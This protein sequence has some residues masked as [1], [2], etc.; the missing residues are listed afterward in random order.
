MNQKP[1]NII[2]KSKQ[3]WAF[4]LFI[5]VVL[6]LV[7]WSGCVTEADD[8]IIILETQTGFNTL[9]EAIKEAKINQT[10]QLKPGV[11]YETIT[12]DKPLK[13]S[14]T[15]RNS[16]IIDGDGNGD[17]IFIL[18]DWVE[19]HNLTIRNSGNQT[20][21]DEDAGV[22][23][24]SEYNTFENLNIS[25]NNNYGLFLYL[26]H[27]NTVKNCVFYQNEEGGA[28]S[29]QCRGNRFENCSFTS[30]DRGIYIHRDNNGTFANNIVSH[31]DIKGIYFYGSR[32]F[33][34]QGNLFSGNDIGMH[35]KGSKFSTFRNN[36]YMGNR[37]GIDFCCGGSDNTVYQNAFMNS[38]EM[39]VTG[40]PINQFDNGSI[41]NFWDDYEGVDENGDGIG[42]T[43]YNV[44]APTYG[45]QN[46]DRYPLMN[47]S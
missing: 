9:D 17:V 46:V 28:F 35:V 31:N 30:N 18:S 37:L 26:A 7:S 21:S 44:T 40:Y 15:H 32:N 36:L 13:I 6:C 27:N 43:V 25:N 22:D 20:A 34:I 4:S 8:K 42:D 1:L 5:V 2:N 38:K 29:F 12:I 47:P 11:Y 45:H 19:I 39:H 33:N 3:K 16:T 23:V 24:R 14:G 41:G 10:I